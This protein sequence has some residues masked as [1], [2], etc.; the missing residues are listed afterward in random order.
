MGFDRDISWDGVLNARDLG[1]LGRIAPG[2]L[3]RMAAPAGL[4]AAGWAAAWDHGVRTV[5]DL[6]EADEG[7]P[8][9]APRPSGLTTV[10]IPLDPPAGTAFHERWI[11]IDNMATPLYLGPLLAEH[12]G[13]VVAAAR[14]IAEAAPG[15][16]VFHC[17]SGKDRT[18]VLAMVLLAV[19]GAATDEIV[20]DYVL[21]FERLK[22]YFDARGVRDQRTAVD[23]LLA[24]HG[25]TIEESVA[26]TIRALVMPDFLLGNGLSEGEFAVLRARL[27]E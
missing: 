25:T 11:P 18:G 14:A 13:P 8:D 6:R 17:A 5:V 16:V 7:E 24:K 9:L 1:G 26:S 27:T 10:R 4:T 23:A 2:R 20:A 22:P 21:T 3:V 15:C 12:P 19:A